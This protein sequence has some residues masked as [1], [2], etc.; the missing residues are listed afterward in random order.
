[1]PLL[2]LA[3]PALLGDGRGDGAGSE[4]FEGPQPSWQATVGRSPRSADRACSGYTIRPTAAKAANGATRRAAAAAGVVLRHDVGRP[5]VIDD[6][7]ISRVAQVR[8]ARRA[9]AGRGA[10][11]ADHRPPHRPAAADPLARLRLQ[12][13]GP[14]AATSAHRRPSTPHPPGTGSCAVNWACRSTAAR[15]CFR[16]S[17]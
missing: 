6:L 14:L 3:L 15:P 8:S 16:R 9:I 1:M 4:G 5:R 12:R 11:A 2:P 13:R 17:C 10:S 7:S